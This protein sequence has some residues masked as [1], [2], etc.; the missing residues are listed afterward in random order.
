MPFNIYIFQA[1]E[2]GDV[3]MKSEWTPKQ[4]DDNE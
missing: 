4:N 2:E 1:M 3:I